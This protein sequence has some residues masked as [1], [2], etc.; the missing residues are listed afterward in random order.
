MIRTRTVRLD[1][2]PTIY[3]DLE[4]RAIERDGGVNDVIRYILTRWID[5]NPLPPADPE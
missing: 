5:A 1:L 4:A 3:E 2:S